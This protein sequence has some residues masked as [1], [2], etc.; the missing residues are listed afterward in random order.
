MKVK[1]SIQYFV[2]STVKYVT[3]FRCVLRCTRTLDACQTKKIVTYG[4]TNILTY[5]I[6]K[7]K[8]KKQ[9]KITNC[10]SRNYCDE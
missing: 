7:K 5:H 6:K 10:T 4:E 3:I 9:R 2:Y 8:E 1:T